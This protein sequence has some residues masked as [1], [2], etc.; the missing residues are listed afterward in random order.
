M[1]RLARPGA[2]LLAGAALAGAA[3]YGRHDGS[4]MRAPAE[5]RILYYIDPMHPA[6]RSEQ[7]GTAPDCGMALVAVYEDGAAD[8][9]VRVSP[10]R[11]RLAGVTIVTVERAPASAT[12]RLYGRVAADETRISR[13]TAGADGY[14]EEMSA[15]AT[16]SRVEKGQWLATLAA[17]D[18]RTPIQAYIV[19]IDARNEGTL[20]PSDVPGA[21][22]DGVD[23]AADRLRTLGMSPEQIA[24][25]A[26]T[27]VVPS[28][29]RLTAPSAGFV[30]ART[31][32]AGRVATGDELFRIADLGRAWIYA[33][34]P[35][36]D[37]AHVR[38]GA[39]AEIPVPGRTDALRARVS[40]EVPPQFDPASQSVRVR[41]DV[42]NPGGLLRPDMFV[43]VRLPIDL[44]EGI[45][46]P[47]DAVLDAGL[48]K[49]V[50]VERA[51]GAFEAREVAT[52]WRFDDR[53]EIVSGLAAG[54]RLVVSGS[55]LLDS[56]SRL[57]HAPGG[58]AP[59]TP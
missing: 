30:L 1:K 46:V 22:G 13:V 40:T 15:V 24:E 51:D 48:K 23:Q 14:I 38:P 29:I 52:G 4:A 36:G 26:R 42:D 21:I 41:L 27:R 53:V 57:R 39:I 20:R 54:D 47:A 7:P 45:A 2:L 43:D 34:L 25:I 50:F 58:G 55:F 5:R 17:P 37:A 28:K 35:A 3:W 16:G 56:E 8:D 49:R 18:S 44:P 11:Q 31:L 9:A 10:E 59:P 19:A 33:D 6:Y 32:A 12:L